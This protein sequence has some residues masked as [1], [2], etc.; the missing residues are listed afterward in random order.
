MSL[1]SLV[2]AV[3][4]GI[5]VLAML[6]GIFGVFLYDQIVSTAKSA[7]SAVGNLKGGLKKP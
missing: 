5:V 6:I 3:L 4:I 1:I 7:F 2:I